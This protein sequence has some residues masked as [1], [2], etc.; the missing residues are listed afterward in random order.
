MRFIYQIFVNC[1]LLIIY[2]VSIWN[3]KARLWVKGRVH[4]FKHIADSY[5]NSKESVWIHCASLGEFEQAKPLIEKLRKSYPQKKIVLSFFSPSG[6][7]ME[8][9]SK[10][11]DFVCYLP[12]DT[13]KNVKKFIDLINPELAI[14]IKSEFWFNFL[15]E[16]DNKQI[17][18]VFVSAKFSSDQYLFKWYGKWFLNHLKAAKTIFVQDELSKKLLNESEFHYAYITGN[19]RVDRVA[20]IAR[21]KQR[22][23][24]IETFKGDSKLVIAGSTWPKDEILITSFIKSKPQLK[25]II[26]PHEI[27]KRHLDHLCRIIGVKNSLL[28]SNINAEDPALKQL[29]IIDKIGILASLYHYAD[30][31]YVGGGFGKGIHNVLEP[32]SFG[33]PIIF[34]PNYSQFKEATDLIKLEA[35]YSVKNNNSFFNVLN[36]LLDNE[37][38]YQLSCNQSTIYIDQ[39]LGASDLVFQ[40]ISEILK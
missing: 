8:K 12:L 39:N 22:N 34:G 24:L 6:Y 36:N 28:Y 9:A 27:E 23:K 32:A 2:V 4:L 18:F 35:A 37:A 7:E 10:E 5:N 21:N 33:K 29:L 40:Q 20:E 17:P 3:S 16:L 14:F 15:Q 26:A 19:T 1:Y 30:I 31:V 13:K 11:V 25:F 38:L